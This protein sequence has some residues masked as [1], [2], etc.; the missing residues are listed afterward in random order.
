MIS[1][2][3]PLVLVID[4]AVEIRELVGHMLRDE[5]F[6]VATAPDGF[7]GFKM[8]AEVPPDVILMDFDLP[9]MDGVEATRYLRRNATTKNI[10]IIAFTGLSVVPDAAR[11]QAKGFCD[12][13]S[14]TS[15]GAGLLQAI[16]RALHR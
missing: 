2:T 12:L 9:G 4:D 5:G 13:V 8:A 14:K 11:L 6:R 16:N 15:D 1:P 3:S 7:Q 10:P